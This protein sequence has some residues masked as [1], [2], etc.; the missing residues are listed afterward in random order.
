[1]PVGTKNN[2]Y[3]SNGILIA[4]IDL[5][6]HVIEYIDFSMKTIT[7]PL[8]VLVLKRETYVLNNSNCLD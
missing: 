3:T 1:M 2:C 7:I 5:V 8:E 4:R 6:G